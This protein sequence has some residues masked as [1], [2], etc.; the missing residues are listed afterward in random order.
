MSGCRA[1]GCRPRRLREL[2]QLP[3][4]EDAGHLITDTTGDRRAS[5]TSVT[6]Q[7]RAALAL[8]AR[9]LRHLLGTA[10]VQVAAATK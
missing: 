7:G 9:A 5:R 1:G 3:K 6:H 8:Y 4:P 10:K 2:P